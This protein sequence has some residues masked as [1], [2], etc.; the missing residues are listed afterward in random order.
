MVRTAAYIAIFLHFLRKCLRKLNVI[1]ASPWESGREFFVIV[2]LSEQ[3]IVVG[4]FYA[5]SDAELMKKVLYGGQPRFLSGIRTRREIADDAALRNKTVP[6]FDTAVRGRAE[7]IAKLRE[8][9]IKFRQG[10]GTCTI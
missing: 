6:V 3:L 10:P 8:T 7:S 4:G 2:P 5:Q 1:P 9:A